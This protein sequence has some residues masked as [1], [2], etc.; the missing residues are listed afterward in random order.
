VLNRREILIVEDNPA[1][2]RLMQEALRVLAPPV[3]VHLVGDG[4]EALQFLRGQGNYTNVPIPSLIFL[5]FNLPKSNSREVL[6]EIKLDPQLRMIPVAVLT[7]SNSDKDVRDAYQLYA[8]CYLNKAGD[9]DGFFRI[10]RSAVHFWLDIASLP[11][12]LTSD[13]RK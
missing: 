11:S 8:N 6:R 10:I 1:D 4:D 9:L 13:R 5:D 7:T 12:D 3:H 2:V